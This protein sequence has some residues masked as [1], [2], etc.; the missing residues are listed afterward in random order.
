MWL[1]GLQYDRLDDSSSKNQSL[2]DF[3]R[4]FS[5][6]FWFS[7]RKGFPRL[8][9]TLM[10]S[11]VGWGCSHR[12]SQ[13]M[14]STCLQLK[15]LGRKFKLSRSPSLE[16]YE[17]VRMFADTPT[18]PFSIHAISLAASRLTGSAETRK[19]VGD[20]LGPS[21]ASVA[22]R[23]VVNATQPYGMRAYVAQDGIIYRASLPANSPV[24]I[25]VPLRLGLDCLNPLYVDLLKTVLRFRLCCGIIGGKASGSMYFL[26]Y[27]GDNVVYMDPHTTQQA[28]E[29][30][31]LFSLETFRSVP[32]LM[33]FSEMD[34]SLSIGFYCENLSHVDELQAYLAKETTLLHVDEK[35]DMSLSSED[36]VLIE[37]GETIPTVVDDDDWVVLPSK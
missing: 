20:W 8:E 19:K 18:A 9:G 36:L 6:H 28:V 15:E 4:D 24:L 10:T 3:L 14:L 35:G 34:P 27:Q 13:M 12:S 32:L 23:G 1:L 17:I 2:V 7:Y 5:S 37:S 29:M 22:L 30:G 26:G 16:V 11:D 31:G 33:P 21:T 25:L